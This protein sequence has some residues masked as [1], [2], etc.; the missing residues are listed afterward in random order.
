MEKD[1]KLKYTVDLIK[2]KLITLW[3]SD[4]SLWFRRRQTAKSLRK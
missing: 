4:K 1:R 2:D 3:R